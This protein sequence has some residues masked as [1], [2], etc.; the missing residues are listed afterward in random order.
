MIA[1]LV[2][3]I[4]VATVF[5]VFVEPEEDSQ[6]VKPRK[7]HPFGNMLT[8]QVANKPLA[9]AQQETGKEDHKKDL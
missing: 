9:A 1:M 7:E 8:S 4:I 3:E 6:H 5:F 2:L